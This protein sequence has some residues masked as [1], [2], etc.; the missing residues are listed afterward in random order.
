MTGSPI[1]VAHGAATHPGLRRRANEDAYLAAAP[2]FLVAD[3]MGGHESGAAASAAVV[4]EFTRLA[5]RPSVGVDDM[6]AALT[7]ARTAVRAISAGARAA[8]TTLSG[9]AI[10]DIGGAGYWLTIN[11]GDSRTY[12]FARGVLE[13]ISVDHSLVQEMLDA[14]VLAPADAAVDRRR[15]EITRAIGAGSEG[16]PDFWLVPA[17]PGDRILVCSDGLSGEVEAERIAEVLAQVSAPMEA[18]TRLVHEAMVRGGRDNIT[19]VIVDAVRVAGSDDD[20]YDT[21]PH[22]RDLAGRGA[23]AD[24]AP[25]LSDI[26]ID[27]D[28]RPRAGAGKGL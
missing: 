22:R 3:G 17:E 1:D 26:D 25:D 5:G 18:A 9:V 21:A 23:V 11:V 13:Q 20:D 12:R 8:G 15:N 10:A 4:T 24:V 6:R 14:G 28:T 7:R 27:T 16:E 19:V 2:L